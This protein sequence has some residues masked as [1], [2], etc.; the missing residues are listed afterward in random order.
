MPRKLKVFRA[1]LGFYDTVV[2]VPSKKAA[3]QAWGSR[4]DLFR[5]GFAKPADDPDAVQD[6]LARPGVVLR[7]PFG[8]TERFSENPGLPRVGGPA[9]KGRAAA[10]RR[11]AE[12][13]KAKKQAELRRLADER[14]R[15]KEEAQARNQAVVRRARDQQ[16]EAKKQAELRRIK[17]E[18]ERALR[19]VAKRRE[20]LARQ[21][22]DIRRQFDSRRGKLDR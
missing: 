5:E 16:Q 8:S 15:R 21:E 18:E 12:E 19:E 20:E 10:A 6:A 3:L 13:E 14:R 2:A 11:K 22:A 1:H 4:Q 7:R 9:P 17:R